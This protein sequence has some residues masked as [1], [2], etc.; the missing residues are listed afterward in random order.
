[1][2]KTSDTAEVLPLREEIVAD[3]T[4]VY[5]ML[6]ALSELHGRHCAFISECGDMA[7][8]TNRAACLESIVHLYNDVETVAAKI[9]DRDANLLEV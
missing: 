2:S 3:R 5:D 6:S 1:M 9:D 4:F 8:A 7:L